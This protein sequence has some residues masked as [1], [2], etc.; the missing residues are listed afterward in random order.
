MSPDSP[1][2]GITEHQHNN[3]EEALIVA[4]DT[5]TVWWFPDGYMLAV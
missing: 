1:V 4:V 2:V 3:T 5:A